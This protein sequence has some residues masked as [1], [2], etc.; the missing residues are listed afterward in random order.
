[1][2]N[3]SYAND[4]TR[5]RSAHILNRHRFGTGISGKTEFPAHWTDEMILEHVSDVASD[6]LS[7]TGVGKWNSPYAT[8]TRDGIDIRVDFYPNGHTTNRGKIST[9]YPLNTPMNP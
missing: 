8:G 6:P 2:H 4:L 3:A 1:M 7:V 5:P 9:A